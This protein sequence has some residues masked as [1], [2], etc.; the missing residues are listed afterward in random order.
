M[1]RIIAT[2]L[3]STMLCSLTAAMAEQ[4]D[5][6]SSATV[7]AASAATQL[8]ELTEEEQAHVEW[9]LAHGFVLNPEQNGY[10][11]ADTDEISSA[12]QNKAGGVNYGAIEWDAEL[13]MAAVR[14]FL[15]GG[16]YLGDASFAQ[17]ETGNNYREMYQLAT[18]YNNVPHNTNL[19][20]VLDA[21]NLHLLGASEAGT[22]KTIEFQRNPKVSVSWCRQL[23]VEDEENYNYY[24]SYGVQIDGTVK[25]YTAADLETEEGA[26][27]LLNL[28]DKYYPTLASTWA[29]Y[30]AGLAGL[31][32]EAAIR[33]AKL[34]YISKGLAAGSMVVYEIVPD[35]I[36]ITA[37]FL[38][39]MVPQMSNAARFTQVQE[40]EDKYAYDLGLSDAFIDRLIAYKNAFMATEEGAAAV[41]AYYAS[42][43]YQMLDSYCEMMQVPTSLDMA[44]LDTNAA[45]LKTQTTYIPQ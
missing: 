19:E 10:I 35:R 44:K 4:T 33:E 36:V 39:N 28:Y 37:P 43:M 18:S 17:D 25:V 9:A 20:M 26:A 8:G 16:K 12:T 38:M 32:D 24:C 41:E 2:I 21:S 34:A 22:G 30:G 3:A 5:A 45:G 27:A 40:G 29:A 23:R 31:E 7:D 1:K 15:K 6:Q 11:K 13:Q 14:E 42:P